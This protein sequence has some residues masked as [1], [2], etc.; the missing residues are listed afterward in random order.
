MRNLCAFALPQPARLLDARR[1]TGYT[2][3]MDFQTAR[4]GGKRLFT[5]ADNHRLAE[6]GLFSEDDPIYQ[7][8]INSTKCKCPAF[9]IFIK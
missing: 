9:C 7:F 3:P 5:S 6:T 1:Q 8:N 2:G 4:P